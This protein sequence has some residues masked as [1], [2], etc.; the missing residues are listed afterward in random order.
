MFLTSYDDLADV[1][2]FTFLVLSLSLVLGNFFRSIDFIFFQQ[3]LQFC[4]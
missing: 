2:C 1:Y 3:K 4:Q